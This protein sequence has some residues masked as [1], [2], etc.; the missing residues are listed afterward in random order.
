MELLGNLASEQR[1]FDF[2]EVMGRFLFCLFLQ[3]AFHEEGLALDLLSGD[4][5]SLE[6]KPDYIGA[7]DQAT[8]CMLS[9][10]L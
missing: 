2:Q 1:E 5:A 9:F 6:N 7:F 10:S 4:P 8:V 3:I